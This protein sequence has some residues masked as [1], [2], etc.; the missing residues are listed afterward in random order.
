[1]FELLRS[2]FELLRSFPVQTS[3]KGLRGLLRSSLMKGGGAQVEGVIGQGEKGR[4]ADEEVARVGF[5]G[6]AGVCDF[7][8]WWEYLLEPQG[9]C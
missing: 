5:L 3:K 4:W 9:C 6:E 2:I 7:G 8:D 1:M